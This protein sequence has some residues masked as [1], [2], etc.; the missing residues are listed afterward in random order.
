MPAKL[1]AWLELTVEEAIDPSLPIC[2]P[3]HHLWDKPQDRY[4]IDEVTSDLGSGHNVVQTLFVE[5]DAM[6]RA[7]GPNDM[8]PVGE[9]EWVNGIGAQSDSGAYGPTRVAAGIVGYADLNLGAEV[10]P[11]LEAIET[12]SGGRFRSVRHTCSWDEFEPLRSHRSGYPGMMASAKFKEGFGVLTG[13]GYGFDALVYHPQILELAELVDAFPNATFILNHIGRPLG[14][15]PY[16]S[17]RDEVFEVWKKDMTTLAERPNIVV[18][19]GGLGNRVSG[20]DWDT[21]PFP[22]SSMELAKTTG[23]YYLHAIETFG[24][25]RCM[26]ESNFPVD[27]NS[28]SYAVIWNSFK[29]MTRDFSDA[30]KALLFHNTAA[31]SYKLPL[32]SEL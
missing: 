24:P 30:E 16:A 9:V 6:Y 27:K 12:A 22:P 19:V 31:K 25:E 28:Y 13:M 23:P 4:M 8:K 7:S 1:D 21:R 10:K 17:H 11:V 18:K 26:F 20:F 3:H 5:V 15:G 32:L 2:D 14:I 29:R